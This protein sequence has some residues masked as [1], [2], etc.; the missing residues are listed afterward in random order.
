MGVRRTPLPVDIELDT[1][2]DD[3]WKPKSIDVDVQPAEI[4]SFYER[5]A[6]VND[7]RRK[8]KA[9]KGLGSLFDKH[10]ADKNKH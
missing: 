9:D 6:I 2:N 3:N 7:F 10:M 4:F 1:K 8:W 5:K